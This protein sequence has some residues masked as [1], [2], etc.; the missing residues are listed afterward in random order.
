MIVRRTVSSAALVAA[1]FLTGCSDER[2]T[3]TGADRDAHG[4]IASA[5]YKWCAKT[6]QCERPWELAQ[7]EKFEKSEEAFNGFCGNK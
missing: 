6:S 7:K 3:V 1:V 2:S 4:C 5:G